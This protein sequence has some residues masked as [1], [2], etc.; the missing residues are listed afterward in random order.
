[1]IQPP[2][3]IDIAA[4]RGLQRKFG[5]VFPAESVIFKE[6]DTSM[7]FYVILQGVVEI[8]K[9]VKPG[10]EGG[11]DQVL[12]LSQLGPG[13]FFGEIGAFSGRPRTATAR[14]VKDTTL[15]FFD[16]YSAI[17]LLQS[18]PR[19]ALGIIQ[20]LCDRLL[21]IDEALVGAA[22]H[23]IGDQPSLDIAVFTA[24]QSTESDED[25]PDIDS[26]VSPHNDPN[27]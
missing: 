18:S 24:G 17:S 20:T 1:M 3:D 4:L 21:R 13:G 10:P 16:G 6:G 19:F 12:T 15:L 27:T 26:N 14:A 9:R 11:S 7:H 25:H 23:M 2:R 5:K 8:T 22:A